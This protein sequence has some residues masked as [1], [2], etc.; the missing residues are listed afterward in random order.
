MIMQPAK[1]AMFDTDIAQA[2]LRRLNLIFL[3]LLGGCSSSDDVQTSVPVEPARYFGSQSCST[4]HEAEYS[5]WQESHHA[6]AMAHA[7]AASVR[8]DFS[9]V[10]FRHFDTTSS[11]YQREDEFYVL[12]DNANGDLE[13]FRIGY[14]FGVD[15][16]Q[17]YL[18]EFEDGRMQALPIAWDTRP[19]SDGGQK[20][21]HLYQDEPIKHDDPLHWTRREHNWNFMCAEC[22][23]TNL[24]KNYDSA[25]DTYASTWTE[26]NV[27]C[28]ACHGPGSNHINQAVS[29]EFDSRYGLVLDLDDAGRATWEM[30]TE[31]GIAARTEFR[32]QIPKQPEACG[33][34]H[35]RRSVTA[36]KYQHGRPLLDTHTPVLLEENLYF[37]DG[38]VREEV[39]VYGSFVQSRMYQA[40]VTCS[41]CHNSHSGALL[42]GSEPSAICATCHLPD[43]FD[44]DEHHHHE[45]ESVACVDCHMPARTYMVVDDRR[46]HSF[47]VPR[48]D[49]TEMTGSPNACNQ[50]HD[51]KDAAWAMTR[52]NAWY[53]DLPSTPHYG[54]ALNAARTSAP[55]ANA[56]LLIALRDPTTP[57]IAK[58]T[59]L[60][61]L[62]SPLSQDVANGIQEALSYG[63][64]A[65]RIGALRAL[66]GLQPDVQADLA[67]PLLSDTVRSV[68][69]A[70]ARIVSPLRSVLPVR[71]EG[72]F[73][74]AEIE[75][76]AALDESAERP[77]SRAYRASLYVDAGDI[78]AA[79]SEFTQTLLMEPYFTTARINFADMYRQFGQDNDAEEVLREGLALTP[80][81]AALHHSLGLVLVRLGRQ[82]D[83]LIELRRAM[84]L[85]RVNP[86]YSFVYAIALNSLGQPREA[87]EFL[88]SIKDQFKNDFDIHWALATMLRDQEEFDAAR[89]VA[90]ELV[91]R[92]PDASQV[93]SLLDSLP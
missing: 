3:I 82:D 14:T 88:Y 29:E 86:R 8:G 23:S 18:I 26:I 71:F 84:E 53:G 9:N 49:L 46:D 69:I 54:S 62:R 83:G 76:I 42:T 64:P 20:W 61:E 52:M 56:K 51:D 17:Q 24:I 37:P 92:F 89:E 35:S 34:C 4:C 28:E 32:T 45:L 43:K 77:E 66:A 15:P 7:S 59:A 74:A 63:D 16:L 93:P 38:Q 65:V 31:T 81:S 19:A 33:R 12:T 48:P 6:Q 85:D 47:R 40:G 60:A 21:F 27:G 78:D 11:F 75:M 2:L 44:S 90:N 68:R 87:T 57:P 39:Y 73:A 55:D 30:N 91:D 50:C 72:P 80:E 79:E 58:A 41:D 1:A 13:E 36:A 67:G 25:A 22:H 5:Q 70:A 10:E